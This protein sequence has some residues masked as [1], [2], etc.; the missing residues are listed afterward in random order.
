MIYI[1]MALCFLASCTDD[2]L[3]PGDDTTSWKAVVTI[4]ETLDAESHYHT[5]GIETEGLVPGKIIRITTDAEWLTIKADTLPADGLFDVLPE[6]NRKTEERVALLTFT[7]QTDGSISHIELVQKG[8]VGVN[9]DPQA[10]YYRV[11]QGFSCF[12]EYK[13]ATSIRKN[14]ID[15][16]K[17]RHMDSDSTFIS[18]QENVRG[19]TFYE[20]NS[21]YS[22]SEMQNK[23]TKNISSSTNLLGFKKTVERYSLV[24]Q[25]ATD[26]QYYGYARL[27]RIV[28]SKSMDE[29]ALK[30]ICRNADFIKAGKLPFSDDFYAV[31]RKIVQ[32]QGNERAKL[33]QNMLR[34]YGT[35]VVIRTSLGGSLDL[36]VTYSHNLVESLET[37]TETVFKTFTGV[38]S[39]SESNH[40]VASSLSAS[41]AVIIHGG[42]RTTKEALERNVANLSANGNNS[43]DSGLLDDWLGSITYTGDEHDALDAVDFS[44][45]PIWDLFSDRTISNEILSAVI[46]M[47]KELKNQLS[48]EDL[49]IDNYALPLT[50][51]MMDFSSDPNATLVRVVCHDNTVPIAEVCNEYV[52]AVRSDK[53]ITVIYPIVNGMTRITMGLFPGDG[54]NRPAY[55]TFSDQSVYVNPI[56][57]Y[58]PTDKL[59]TIYYLHGALYPDNQGIDLKK[60]NLT[61]KKHHLKFLNSKQIYPVVKIGSG[62]WTR[63]DIKEY[64]EWGYKNLYGRFIFTED[65]VGENN[66]A[67]VYF[68]QSKAFMA[69]NEDFYS[70]HADDVYGR[71]K[72]YVPRTSDMNHLTRYLGHN[73]KTL[74]QGQQS[75]FEAKFLGRCTDRDFI[76]EEPLDEMKRENVGTCC[77][78][79][80]KDVNTSVSA[81]EVSGASVLL[82]KADYS[83]VT[84]PD[85]EVRFY[86]YPVRVFRTSYYNYRK[87][88]I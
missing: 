86:Y 35:H 80:F 76:T 2:T 79:V 70:N 38:K 28:A 55:L 60:A 29:G 12:D 50:Q 44:F 52:P 62:Y 71:T 39:S 83:W 88:G 16:A 57:N 24:S 15:E 48:D 25:H 45:I 81:G 66:F 8:M 63:S 5:V 43:L 49:G 33:I 75:G 40:S 85:A 74:L 17:L 68:T 56:D 47:S 51:S 36:A 26:E 53:R 31:Y 30:Y 37:T 82:M 6:A 10:S 67:R 32:A 46:T 9:D 77:Y 41:G 3:R 65:M 1:C 42:S 61:V 87:S 64:M 11:G 27:V 14:V 59:D 23:L 84:V 73:H 4:G 69:L 22:L 34:D 19:E 18:L 20:F 21:A 58:G 54:E 72:W 7:N 78:I 13:S